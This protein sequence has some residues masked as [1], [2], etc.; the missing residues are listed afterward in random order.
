MEEGSWAKD[1]MT[2]RTGSAGG[3]RK[4]GQ[5]SGELLGSAGGPQRGPWAGAYAFAHRRCTCYVGGLHVH[6][7]DLELAAGARRR[8]GLLPVLGDCICAEGG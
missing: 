3:R 1:E 4:C 7:V 8:S 5:H 6:E 2:S